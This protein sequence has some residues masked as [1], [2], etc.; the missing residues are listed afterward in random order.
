[1]P[2]ASILDVYAAVLGSCTI[3][4]EKSIVDNVLSRIAGAV[5]ARSMIAT[6]TD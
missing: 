3:E 1:L 6:V 4:S 5:P 2:K